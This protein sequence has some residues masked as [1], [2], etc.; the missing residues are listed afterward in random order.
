MKWVAI[1][2]IFLFSNVCYGQRLVSNVKLPT[3]DDST[4]TPNITWNVWDTPNFEVWSIDKGQGEQFQA[5]IE[6]LRDWVYRRWGFVNRY[7]ITPNFNVKCIIYCVPNSELMISL[8]HLAGPAFVSQNRNVLWVIL[9]RKATE[10]IPPVLTVVCFRE[11]ISFWAVRGTSVLNSTLPQIG[12]KFAPFKTMLETN[13]QIWWSKSL[14]EM[15]ET[16]WLQLTEEQKKLY[17]SQAA[18]LCLMLRKE[19]GQDICLQTITKPMTEN[20]MSVIVGFRDYVDLDA[21]FKRFMYYMAVD[22]QS[23]RMPTEYLLIT[24]K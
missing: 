16:Q 15:T 22:I 6:V 9:D 4:T 19:F 11:Q 12:S 5:S 23:G 8:F 13:Q 1:G 14:F 2:L 7:N 18:A 24:K 21:T 3:V 10:V 20:R 17:D